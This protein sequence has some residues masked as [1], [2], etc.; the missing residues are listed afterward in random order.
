MRGVDG[1]GARYIL[2]HSRRTQWRAKVIRV[3]DVA[4]NPR[5]IG[6]KSCASL[7]AF[8][9]IFETTL[10]AQRAI[11]VL[12]TIIL[13]L[14]LY[15]LERETEYR[16]RGIASWP[17]PIIVPGGTAIYRLR[18]GR[19]RVAAPQ[20]WALFSPLFIYLFSFFF[21]GRLRGGPH[22]VNHPCQAVDLVDERSPEN[23]RSYSALFLAHSSR[24]W[25]PC[26]ASFL[27]AYLFLVIPL[28]PRAND[29]GINSTTGTGY[30]VL[31]KREGPRLDPRDIGTRWGILAEIID[32]RATFRRGMTRERFV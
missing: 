20:R 10:P 1:K 15:N 3:I 6:W 18:G 2:G 31:R 30:Q 11:R 9:S 24:M 14:L 5:E 8:V 13:I 22:G 27:F 16:G 26:P 32:T 4:E 12:R 7:N 28:P 17:R 19:K 29:K 21:P 25:S 23:H